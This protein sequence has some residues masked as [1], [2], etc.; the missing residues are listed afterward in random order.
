[1]TP[2]YSKLLLHEI[3]IPEAGASQLQ[4]M[5]DMT[6]MA[7]NGGIERTKQQWTALSEKPGLKVVQLWGPAEEDDGGIVEVVKA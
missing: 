7:F 5:L 3:I 2:G 1:M 6:M 4:A